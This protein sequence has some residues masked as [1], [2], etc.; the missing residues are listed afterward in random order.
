MSE[1]KVTQTTMMKGAPTTGH[2]CFVAPARPVQSLEEYFEFL[3][4]ANGALETPPSVCPKQPH[5][6]SNLRVKGIGNGK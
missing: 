6:T 3:F 1:I 4:C 2:P 5:M